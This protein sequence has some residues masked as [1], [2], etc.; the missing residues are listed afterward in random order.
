[1][2]GTKT[3]SGMLPSPQ[4]V[5]TVHITGNIVKVEM[6]AY[7]TII[8]DGIGGEVGA[9]IFYGTVTLKLGNMEITFEG[10][11]GSYGISAIIRDVE[12]KF[13]ES[14]GVGGSVSVQFK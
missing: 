12:I 7:H 11:L 1:M 6:A 8:E 4:K 5:D 3:T 10:D 14:I 2:L 13:G 9:A